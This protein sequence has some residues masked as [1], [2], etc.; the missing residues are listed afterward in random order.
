MED[1]AQCCEDSLV[2]SSSDQMEITACSL[3]SD[4]IVEKLYVS[5]D[6]REQ[7]PPNDWT[8]GTIVSMGGIGKVHFCMKRLLKAMLSY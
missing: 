3:K 1:I 2:S 6:K 7:L 5:I 8:F 4:G